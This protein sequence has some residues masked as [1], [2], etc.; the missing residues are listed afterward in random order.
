MLNTRTRQPATP[1]LVTLV[2]LHYYGGSIRSWDVVVDALAHE[3]RCLV[4]DLPGF[5]ESSPLSDHQDVDEVAAVVAEAIAEQLGHDP[6]VLVGHSMGGKIALAIAAGLP[7]KPQPAGLRAMV[8]L[9]TS[10]PGSEPIPDDSRQQMLDKP[11]LPPEKQREA[12]EKTL[13]QI[14]RKPL[15]KAQQAQI[16]ADNL[17]A[18]SE[19]WIAW[20]AVGSRTDITNRMPRITVP[21]TLLVGD[22][23]EAL[24]PSVQP[25]MVQPYLPQATLHIIPGAG[26]LLPLEV[27]DEVVERILDTC[28]HLV[29][30]R[31]T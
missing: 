4:I 3:F 29:N 19:G 21:V 9:A 5:G 13:A 24:P 27:P 8:L 23:D 2:F 26:H 28:K 15:S 31:L 11:S 25:D 14:T 7:G 18:S 6:F 10:P 20:P 12:A 22:A 16:I 1:S 17:R 30:L